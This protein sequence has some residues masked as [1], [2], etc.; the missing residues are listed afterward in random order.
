MT[1]KKLLELAKEGQKYAYTP[2]SNFKVGACILTES[3]K[4]YTGCN[5]ENGAYSP[6]LC[7]ERTAI[8][9]AISE[10]ETKIEAVAVV[11]SGEG[12]CTPC[13]V[14]RQFLAEFNINMRVICTNQK[15]DIREYTL[16]QLLPE[17]FILDE[18]VY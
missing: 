18:Q 4:T 13:G 14:C 5:I 11:G 1:N 10:G 12:F 8:A 9:K 17:T 3:G 15:G 2:Y 7:A 6:S 16:R